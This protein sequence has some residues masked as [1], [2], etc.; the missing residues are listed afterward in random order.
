MSKGKTCFLL[1]LPAVGGVEKH[2]LVVE[3]IHIVHPNEVNL[4]TARPYTASLAG[5]GHTRKTSGS[6]L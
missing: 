6:R 2:G 3:P 1:G 5:F 4:K